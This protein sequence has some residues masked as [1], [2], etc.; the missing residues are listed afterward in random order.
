M[1]FTVLA[2]VIRSGITI[3]VTVRHYNDGSRWFELSAAADLAKA[4]DCSGQ[5]RRSSA[6]NRWRLG[7][8]VERDEI[9][10]VEMARGKGCG[11]ASA[12]RNSTCR[13]VSEQGSERV[14]MTEQAFKEAISSEVA[15]AV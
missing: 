9:K 7:D 10:R 6:A 14:N 4:A 1:V 8:T 12:G 13:H 15:Q 3:V 2:A 11:S 5:W